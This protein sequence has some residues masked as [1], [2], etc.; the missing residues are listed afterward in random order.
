MTNCDFNLIKEDLLSL[1][2]SQGDSVLVHSSF[3]SLGEVKGGIETLVS[4]L[5][6]GVV[7]SFIF[8][9][10]NIAVLIASTVLAVLGILL[11]VLSRVRLGY[12]HRIGIAGLIVGII[13]TV[14]NLFYIIAV[15]IIIAALI[16][17]F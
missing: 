13:V 16:S 8:L 5:L 9:W 4:A 10:D 14:V 1:G 17:A 2:L 15:L 6:S 11:A 3:K 7:F 12:F